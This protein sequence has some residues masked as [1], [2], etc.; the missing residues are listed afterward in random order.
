VGE[1]RTAVALA[2][3]LGI[4]TTHQVDAAMFC[5][6]PSKPYCLDSFGDFSDQWEFE[7]CRSEVEGFVQKSKRY[8]E[9]LSEAR[10]DA[11]EKANTVVERFNCKARRER[12]CP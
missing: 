12:F 10:S 9:C 4:V 2:G 3:L 7:K 1:I 5:S 11:V 6:E 8:A